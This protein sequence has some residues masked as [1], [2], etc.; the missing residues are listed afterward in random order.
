MSASAIRLPEQLQGLDGLI[1]PGGESTTISKLM[2]KYGF[3][4]AIP[5]AFESGMAL[6][7][8][9]AGSILLAKDII[10]GIDGQRGLEMMD[11]CVRRNAFGRQI[12]SFEAT[13]DF[14]HVGPYQGIFIRAPWI[15]S[16]GEGVEI[17]SLF[18]H[19]IVAARQ[20]RMM[21]CSFHPELTGDLGVHR[22]F[23]EHVV[24]S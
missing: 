2:D 11:V 4:E 15:E 17:L 1:I 12:D 24:N 21:V 23:I 5:A 20:D 14:K 8:T 10:D 3:F 6:W 16:V 22:Y 9:C 18:D 7:G 19:K 13:I